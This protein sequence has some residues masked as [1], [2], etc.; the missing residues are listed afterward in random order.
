MPQSL[1][2]NIVYYRHRTSINRLLYNTVLDS[3]ELYSTIH[4]TKSAKGRTLFVNYYSSFENSTKE[5]QDGLDD[6]DAAPS[7]KPPALTR[8]H[9]AEAGT[10]NG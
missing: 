7:G 4:R 8:L 6:G 10:Q 1:G 9:V 3:S 2:E 5:E